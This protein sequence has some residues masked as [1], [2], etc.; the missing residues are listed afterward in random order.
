MRPTLVSCA[1]SPLRMPRPPDVLD[2][3]RLAARFRTARMGDLYGATPAAGLY[4]TEHRRRPRER[5]TD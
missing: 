4:R 5:D 2:A 3:S 1:S